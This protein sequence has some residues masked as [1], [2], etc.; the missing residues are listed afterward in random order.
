VAYLVFSATAEWT[1][2]LTRFDL[3]TGVRSIL[4]KGTRRMSFPRWSPDGSRIA[5][6]DDGERYGFF[7]AAFVVPA[8]RGQ[9]PA[10]NISLSV[11]RNVL[12]LDW[13]PEGHSL[14]AELQD[15]VNMPI[16]RLSLNG[17]FEPISRSD[18][19][20]TQM[21]VAHSGSLA[22]VESEPE[23]LDRIWIGDAHAAQAQPVVDPNPQM[24]DWKLGPQRVIRWRNSRGDEL[25]GILTLPPDYRTGTRVPL[26]VDPYSHR[27]N[28]FKGVTILANRY[29]AAQG[30]G[31]FFPNHRGFFT[32]PKS[33]EG[34]AYA[35][36]AQLPNSADIMADDI[37]SGVDELVREGVADPDRLGL[38]S[39]STGASGIDALL[40]KTTRF[41]AAVSGGGVADWIHYYLLRPTDDDT[42]PSL[43]EGRTPW[44]APDLYRALSPVYQADRIYTPL[45]LFVGDKDTRLLDSVHFYHA[46]RRLNRP[47]TLVRYPDQ[48]HGV[49]GDKLQEHWQRCVT[50][51]RQYGVR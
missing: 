20:R 32:V 10:R 39:F 18:V 29:L 34:V 19:K 23:H 51:F 27:C 33:L 4:A 43:L 37:L 1:A 46:L 22:W 42:I 25:E 14:I 13:S 2:E 47:V 9:G 36:I 11:D 26:I 38:Y 12:G 24:V 5:Y 6:L 40:T 31:L 49:P 17:R 3:A 41:K 7:T 48:G 50:F 45:L 8:S 15:G 28:D 21:S 35:K 30:Y 44:D 16:G